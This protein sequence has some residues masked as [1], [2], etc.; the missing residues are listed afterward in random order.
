MTFGR[1]SIH[2]WSFSLPGK[3]ASMTPS[4]MDRMPCP[5]RTSIAIPRRMSTRASRFLRIKSGTRTI[6]GFRSSQ[7]CLFALEKESSGMWITIQGIAIAP[8]NRPI[9]EPMEIHTRLSLEIHCSI[10]S[11]KSIDSY[12]P[13]FSESLLCQGREGYRERPSIGPN[14]PNLLLMSRL[15]L[16]KEAW[17]T[18]PC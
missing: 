15:T 10:V 17:Y 5:G 2:C 4:K 14:A 12:G 13:P 8:I 1:A 9:P 6:A 11:K 16:A 3:S 18:V 7:F